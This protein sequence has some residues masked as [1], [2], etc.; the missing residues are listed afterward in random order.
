MGELNRW[1]G[2][3]RARSDPCVAEHPREPWSIHGFIF[4]ALMTSPVRVDVLGRRISVDLAWRPA[5][6]PHLQ[7]R[8]YLTCN[9]SW[10]NAMIIN[11]TNQKT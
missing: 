10:W 9:T 1:V 8:F 4:K 5:I 2:R 6:G 11:M 3:V 7:L